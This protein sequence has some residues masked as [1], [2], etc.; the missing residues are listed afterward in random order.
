MKTGLYLKIL[1][2]LFLF[3]LKNNKN[4]QKFLI[5]NL[6][7]STFLCNF[8]E[9]FLL[10]NEEKIIIKINKLSIIQLFLIGLFF[11]IILVYISM[12]NFTLFC[13]ISF[14]FYIYKVLYK[15][16]V[17]FI[18]EK[19]NTTKSLFVKLNIKKSPKKNVNYI[20][21]RN[22][23]SAAGS[24]GRKLAEKAFATAMGGVTTHTLYDMWERELRRRKDREDQ[25]A[26]LKTKQEKNRILEKKVD[27]KIQGI[28]KENIELKK[29][30]SS[31]KEENSSLK[32]KR[33]WF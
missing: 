6:N 25:A 20:N 10:F 3:N 12:L 8:I 33:R 13:F 17:L 24:G 21:I 16:L 27:A 4:I 31:L 28:K 32:N 14:M 15:N 22:M 2:L 19:N 1:P 23:A 26:L 5:A 9:R 11:L 30:N 18:D 7:K 29:E